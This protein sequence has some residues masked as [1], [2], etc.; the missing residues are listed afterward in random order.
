MQIDTVLISLKKF[1]KPVCVKA[2]KAKSFP[3]A[4]IE[5]KI[6]LCRCSAQKIVTESGTIFPKKPSLSASKIIS[7][8]PT[9][10]YQI[11]CQR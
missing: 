6:L 5:V 10:Q 8:I 11:H 9:K 2:K 1:L 7:L 4:P 3:L